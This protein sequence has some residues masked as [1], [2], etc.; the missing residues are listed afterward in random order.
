MRIKLKTIFTAVIGVLLLAQP[1]ASPATA[2]ASANT[3]P[4]GTNSGA[5]L[6]STMAQ[7][8]GDPVIAKGN[9]FEIKQSSLDQ[10]MAGIRAAAAERNQVISPNQLKLMQGEML[11][12]LIQIQLLLQKSTEVD[13]AKGEKTADT[14]IKTLLDRAGSQEALDRQFMALGMTTAQLRKQ[15]ET[16]NT[17]QATLVRELKITVSD[18]EAK[19]FYDEHPGEFELPERVRIQQIFLSTHDPLTGMELSDADKAAKKKQAEDI[20]KRARSGADFT[21]L[22]E[23]YSDDPAAKKNGGEYTIARGQTLP[24]FEAAAFSLNT[25]QI[26]DVVT[27]ASGY[28]IIKLLAKL[29]SKKLDY[30]SVLPNQTPPNALT[31]SDSIKTFLTNQKAR[32]MAPPYLATL[33]KQADVQILDPDLK[34]A[35]QQVEAE[36]STNAP[37]SAPLG[38]K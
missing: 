34:D 2:N 9:G 13:R 28:H 23:Q 33:R 21:K 30:D 4:A 1:S 5:N 35:V 10:A 16:E 31:V 27:T 8:F 37:A 17:A 14:Q 32:K 38:G 18:A 15:L 20:L 12:R 19:Q 3:A 6:N 22:A 26:S 36:M 24:E 25:N 29:P 7:L 11:D